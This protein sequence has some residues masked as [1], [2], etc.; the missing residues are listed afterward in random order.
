MK[1]KIVILLLC[2]LV[3]AGCEN[4]KKDFSTTTETESNED[5]LVDD[6]TYDSE[7]FEEIDVDK[8]IQ[9]Y[10]NSEPTLIYFGSS[11]CTY[12]LSFKPIA[13]KFAL[14]NKVMVYFLDISTIT[15]DDQEK[16]LDIVTF[17]YIPY[18]TVYKNKE[19]LWGD[20]GV[21]DYNEL[22]NLALEYGVLS[23]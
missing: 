21:L 6:G 12:C 22:K 19:K 1:K 18:I 9:L 11:S 20:S 5:I 7:Y 2:L 23:E 10:A 3:F 8:F 13:K 17:D 15:S 16:L 14:D 4:T